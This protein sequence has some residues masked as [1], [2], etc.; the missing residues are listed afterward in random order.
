MKIA[1]DA[2]DAAEV[3]YGTHFTPGNWRDIL[4]WFSIFLNKMQLT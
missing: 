3:R 1:Q 2:A 4:C